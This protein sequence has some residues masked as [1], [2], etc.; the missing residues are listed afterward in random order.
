MALTEPAYDV[1]PDRER[2]SLARWYGE[3]LEFKDAG[4]VVD[5]GLTDAARQVVHAGPLVRQSEMGP[6]KRSMP[7]WK[8]LWVVLFDNYL[9]MTKEKG[10]G[11]GLK[12]VVW[13]HPVRLELLELESL[14]MRPVQRNNT[15]SRMMGTGRSDSPGRI[16]PDPALCLDLGNDAFYPLSFHSHGKHGASYTLYASTME[17]RNDW[18]RRIM[19]AITVRR[20]LLESISIFRLATITADTASSQVT[21]AQQ[22]GLVTGQVSCT[23]PFGTPDGRHLFAMGSEDGVW[24]GIPHRP[25]SI[26][27]VMSLRMVTQI[28]FLVEFGLFIILAEKILY[29]VDIHSVVPNAIQETDQPVFGIQR[30][31]N[32]S[33]PVL[34]FSVGRLSDR[35]LIIS[36][37][38]RGLESVFRIL[39]VTRSSISEGQPKIYVS[40][41]FFLPSDSHDLLFLKAKICILC[42]HGFEIM[43]LADF[44]SATIPAEEELRSVGKRPGACKPLAMFRIREDEFLL[45]YDE[46]GLYV[47]KRGTPSRSPPTIEWEGTALQAAWHA[48]YVLLFTDSFIEVRHVESGRLAQ[49]VSGKNIRCLWDGRGV[50]PQEQAFAGL[51]AF[52]DPRTPRVHAV[53]DDYDMSPF[54]TQAH[55]RDV[56]PRQRVVELIPTERLIVPGTRYSPSLLS[57]ADTLPPYTP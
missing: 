29:A 24:I 54:M 31:S 19:Q 20:E 13:K 14:A 11:P 1:S 32:P 53:L 3:R 17:Q 33:V 8:Q 51:D 28:A 27:R 44:S 18:R 40:K 45:C 46:F 47:D 56:L 49:I 23:L 2:F 6:L 7:G 4:A 9:V 21:P 34:F 55:P 22:P 41:D 26:R 50:V 15:L 5:L 42:T 52:E 38:R 36:K 37:R 48:P 43:D 12:Y 35:T 25:E 39:E 57:V 10:H 30:I 16:S